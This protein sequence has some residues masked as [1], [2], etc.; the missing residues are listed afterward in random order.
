[1]WRGYA[2]HRP[3]RRANACFTSRTG[4]PE[5]QEVKRLLAMMIVLCATSSAQGW[6]SLGAPQ[7]AQTAHPAVV[8]VTA[9]ERN[10]AS[11]GSGV[12][13]AVDATHGLVITNWHVVRDATGPV[14]VSFPGGFGSGALVLKTDHTWDL[15]A[16]AIARPPVEPVMISTAPARPGEVLTIAGY[17]SDS[18]RA[19]SGHCTE[20]LSPGGNNPNEIVEVDI[21]ARHGD[22]GGPIFNARGEL[23]GVLFGSN[24]SLF[25][26]QYTM[27]SYCGRVRLF[28]A[29]VNGDFRR[30]PSNAAQLA[31]Q[32]TPTLEPAPP[33]AIVAQASPPPSYDTAMPPPLPMYRQTQPPPATANGSMAAGM[34]DR[35][36]PQIAVSTAGQVSQPSESGGVGMPAR[37]IGQANTA[38]AP[39]RAEQIKTILAVIGVFALMFHAIRLVGAATQ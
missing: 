15:A 14:L 18:Y 21:A 22:S 9:I 3:C 1:M 17:G 2:F 31:Q 29:S 11:L 30:L 6:P 35:V 39:S 38:A 24:D 5:I 25:L 20:Y 7:P 34:T 12:L 33:A 27:G 8:R 16:L 23:A 37:Y 36:S 32:R 13:V 26:G 28:L 4:T 19:V 10:G